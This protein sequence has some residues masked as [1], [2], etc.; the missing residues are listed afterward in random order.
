MKKIVFCVAMLAYSLVP[1]HAEFP[2]ICTIVSSSDLKSD[3]VGDK[4][5]IRHNSIHV[6]TKGDSWFARRNKGF[7][8]TF[9]N[10]PGKMMKWTGYADT[11]YGV[12]KSVTFEA[13]WTSLGQKNSDGFVVSR[14][15]EAIYRGGKEEYRMESECEDVNQKD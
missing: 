5:G 9:Q 15:T 4:I 7:N 12:E 3:K 2:V 6:Y 10:F 1:A 13:V 8:I 11:E 14:Y